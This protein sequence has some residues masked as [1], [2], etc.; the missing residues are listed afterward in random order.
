[1]R[2]FLGESVL[3]VD[4]F[5][6]DSDFER[7]VD[8]GDGMGGGVE[9]VLS[10]E[11]HGTERRDEGRQSAEDSVEE[12]AENERTKKKEGLTQSRTSR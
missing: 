7:R 8:S 1:M 3:A 5:G 9:G 12:G 4:R 6:S 2:G 10:R 11:E